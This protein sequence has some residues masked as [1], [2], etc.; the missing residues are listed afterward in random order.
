ME[1]NFT[2]LET[3]IAGISPETRFM[4]PKL[5]SKPPCHAMARWRLCQ[6]S[7]GFCIKIVDWNGVESWDEVIQSCRSKRNSSESWVRSIHLFCKSQGVSDGFPGQL[8]GFRRTDLYE[9]RKGYKGDRSRHSPVH[10]SVLLLSR[11]DSWR[12]VTTKYLWKWNYD[13]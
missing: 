10:F 7:A 12:S 8:P 9:F 6:H 5:L 13:S 3:R 2:L 4:Q 1:D 11:P